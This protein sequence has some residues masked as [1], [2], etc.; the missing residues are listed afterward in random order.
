MRARSLPQFGEGSLSPVPARAGG[1]DDPD[2]TREFGGADAL[3]AQL[4]QRLR[5]ARPLASKRHLR[6][7]CDLDFP[8]PGRVPTER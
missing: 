8:E 6:G 1:G 4:Y 7:A 3:A 2:E 5:K